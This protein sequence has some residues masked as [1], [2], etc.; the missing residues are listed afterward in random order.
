M[1]TNKLSFFKHRKKKHLNQTIVIEDSDSDSGNERSNKTAFCDVA[2]RSDV[3]EGET[4]SD[5]VE[6]ETRNDVDEEETESDVEEGKAGSDV[7]EGETRIGIDEG[8]TG[9]DVEE[10]ETRNG[11]DEGGTGSVAEEG[12]T[13]NNVEIMLIESDDEAMTSDEEK[14]AVKR[15]ENDQ[16]LDFFNDYESL[17]IFKKGTYLP[18]YADYFRDLHTNPPESRC[19]CTELPP[20]V[21]DNL[22]FVVS[23]K[24]KVMFPLMILAVMA[25]VVGGRM[26]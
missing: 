25:T 14:K 16:E 13:R 18:T 15:N 4:G 26:G 12:E 5:V 1:K 24:K 23:I 19:V 10:G 20:L 9:S 21:E 8:G 11:I 17:P 22:S 7:E 2:S 6:G 3:E